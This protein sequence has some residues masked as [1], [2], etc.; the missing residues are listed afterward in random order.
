MYAVG[1]NSPRHT[2]FK[3]AEGLPA[4]S[5]G[6]AFATG[7]HRPEE[8][9]PRVVRTNPEHGATDV[10][11]GLGTISVTFDRPMRRHIWSWVHQPE[12]GEYPGA[13]ERSP[14]FDGDDLTCTLPVLLAPGTV[15]AVSV[16][17]YRHTGFKSRSG[18]P[19]LP[20]AWAF[21]TRDE[22]PER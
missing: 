21:K 9:P 19:S 17:S 11:P 18:A 1:V 12:R 14:G 7:G 10:D 4:L 22:T 15:Y 5:L 6:W 13:P 2:G 16:N 3:D 20:F 8:M